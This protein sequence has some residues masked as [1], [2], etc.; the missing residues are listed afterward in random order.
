MNISDMSVI[1]ET[2]QDEILPLKEEAPS[3]IPDMSVTLDRSGESVAR[4][5]MFVAP[6][7]ASRIV[8]HWMLPHWS[9][10]MILR[11]L[12]SSPP[13]CIREKFPSILIVCSPGEAYVCVWDPI[14]LDDLVPSPQSI[15]YVLWAP[16]TG[17]VMD[18]LGDTVLQVVTK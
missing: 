1:R 2:S 9:M 18:S 3:N 5:A 12:D 14:T 4:Y 8:I 10:D 6:A 7:N 13:R 17:M 16:P 15:W 11:A